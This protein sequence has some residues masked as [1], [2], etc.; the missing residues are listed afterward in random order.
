MSDGLKLAV[1]GDHT[2]LAAE[3]VHEAMG[4]ALALLSE[5]STQLGVSGGSWTLN[6]LSLGSATMVL[7]NPNAVGA[8]ALV[9]S[10]IEELRQSA[11]IPDRWTL[12]MVRRALKLGELVGRRGVRSVSLGR[13]SGHV[14]PVDGEV[15]AHAGAAIAPQET[16]VGSV[17]GTVDM[18]QARRGR[19]VGLT[20]DSGETIRAT[21]PLDLT[22]RVLNVAL[23]HRVLIHGEVQR[24][25]A[26][27]RVSINIL[28]VERADRPIP[29]DIST[30]AGLYADVAAAGVTVSDVLEHRA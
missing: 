5:A 20:L 11:R 8:V 24:N 28:E 25:G 23:G 27:Q 21:Y 12:R 10:G 7:S 19:T 15:T 14:T 18:W 1:G 2:E 9:T 29:R 3:A 22:D 30:L 6:E 17:I 4:G 13:A 26:G 16:A